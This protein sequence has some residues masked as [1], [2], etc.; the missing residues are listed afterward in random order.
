PRQAQGRRRPRR[1]RRK[2][3]SRRGRGGGRERE[4]E[5]TRDFA[6]LGALGGVLLT[7]GHPS[8]RCSAGSRTVGR[9]LHSCETRGFPAWE[10]PKEPFSCPSCW[11]CTQVPS[12]CRCMHYRR[13]WYC[14]ALKVIGAR[15]PFSGDG[16]GSALSR[17]HHMFATGGCSI[18]SPGS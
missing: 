1:N 6:C 10:R 9:P 7:V 5:A 11:R 12:H 2:R 8:N 14:L 16:K 18:C 4:R 17:W 3:R 15:R 13:L